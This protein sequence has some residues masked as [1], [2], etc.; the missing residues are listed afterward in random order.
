MSTVDVKIQRL[1]NS[2]PGYWG[3]R[4]LAQLGYATK[5]SKV[6]DG[7]YEAQI[8][9]AVNELWTGAE[10][11]GAITKEAALRVE[12]SISELSEVA[13]AYRM[14]LVAHAHIDMNWMWGWHE[15]VAVTLDTFRTMLE[16]IKEYPEFKFS[17]SQAA[18][19]RIVERYA[20][21]ML[22]EIRARVQEGRWEVTASHWVEAD[23]NLPSGESLARHLLYTK[24]YLPEL[25]GVS[26]ESLELDF[27]PDTFGHSLN[28]PEILASGG[29]R[30][31]YH[32]RGYD[33]HSLYR[34]VAPSGRAVLVYREPL[35][36]NATIRPDMAL[37]VPEF[38]EEHGLNTM[39]KVYGVGDHGGG[40]TRRDLERI[41][42]MATWPVFPT[43]EFGT[44]RDFYS[45]V[46]GIADSLPEVRGELN[47]VFTG[48]YTSQSRIKMANR[49]GEAALY[50]AELL[51]SLAAASTSFVYPGAS[52]GA[53]WENVLFNQFHDILP[54]SGVIETRE[55][56]LGLFQ[57]TMAAANS[58]RS[59]VLQ[60]LAAQVDTS[61][62]TTDEEVQGSTSE[63]AG[64]G[65]GAR[66][67]LVSRPER[68]RGKVRIFHLF[69]PSPFERSECA[70]LVVWDWQGNVDSLIFQ[71]E[72]GNTAEHQLL[73]AG[74][75]PYWDHRYLRVLLKANVPACGYRTYMM[76]EAAFEIP[77]P[78]PRDPRL[79]RP[80]VFVL[81]NRLICATFDPKSAALISLID[82]ASG[83]E[84]VDGSRGGGM[85]RLIEED[86]AKG[87]TAWIVGRYMKVNELTEEV[88]LSHV[89]YPS[90]SLRR[91]ITYEVK[92]SRST[93]RVII[94]LDEDSR[95]LQYQVECDWLEVGKK[96]ESIPQ[97][98]F[99]LPLGYPCE[100]YRFDVP[101]GTILR[102]PMALD[103]PG[104]SWMLGVRERGSSLMLVTDSK[105]GF[106][107]VD[108]ALNL[109]LLRS[110]FDPDPYPELGTHKF[111]FALC[112]VESSSNKALIAH[113]HRF[114]HPF[115]P[116]SGTVHEGSLPAAASLLSL[117]S[118]GVVLSAVKGAESGEKQLVIRVYETEGKSAKATLRLPEKVR[119]A[120]Y[121]DLNER[122][123]ETESEV[124]VDG[125]SV[126]FEV[127]AFSV[128]SLCVELA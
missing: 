19:Y 37:Y 48:C 98:N 76:D 103:V 78:L 15:T 28:V 16:L 105:Q 18:I 47:F 30:F 10:A 91:A 17:Q 58:V 51:A 56:A 40:P 42:D 93:L 119:S 4:I 66:A 46:E 67:Y 94:S 71:D 87:M 7:Q 110:S 62:L 39:L 100:S 108:D 122:A 123:L 128:A 2:S 63:G 120:F 96:G 53:A 126:S 29:V 99:H 72:A 118:E 109:T 54:G 59:L 57:E 34:W 32:C 86:P 13:K 6:K 77:T 83:E 97:L 90:T 20:P 61:G 41:Q 9:S 125:K 52:L 79:E 82:K 80:D 81:E 31:Y 35:W 27:E 127:P 55:H 104:N 3:E 21:E 64:V 50:E 92:F 101:F 113:A 89:L 1:L 111:R 45:L 73:D 68:G 36:Y 124:T 25:L 121:V 69:N 23:K 102:P 43:L 74:L 12:E 85:F 11:E 75:H 65:F 70:E 33:G 88:K 117:E 38:C 112:L 116:L 60:H 14:I 24:R 95:D 44:F 5:L 49:L 115:T 107:G 22:A 106:R 26:P 114:N 84:F 8:A